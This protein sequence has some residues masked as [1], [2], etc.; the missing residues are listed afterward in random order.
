MVEEF[1]L[2]G[3]REDRIERGSVAMRGSHVPRHRDTWTTKRRNPEAHTKELPSHTNT[4]TSH[5]YGLVI[6]RVRM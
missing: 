5:R 3:M 1:T 6:H 4:K 2:A